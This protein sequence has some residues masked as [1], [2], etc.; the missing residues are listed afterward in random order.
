MT[1]AKMMMKTFF[2]AII[3]FGFLGCSSK[4]ELFK[5]KE[6]E[7]AQANEPV[8]ET[9]RMEETTDRTVCQGPPSPKAKLDKG[10]WHLEFMGSD[11]IKRRYIYEFDEDSIFIQAYCSGDG[12]EIR[13]RLGAAAVI[14]ENTIQISESDS[15]T[16]SV[17]GL[18]GVAV[19]CT[20]EIEPTGIINYSFVGP[21]LQFEENGKVTVFAPSYL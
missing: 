4:G 11:G 7:E 20:A 10:I 21:C 13:S 15:D 17:P 12:I 8:E 9:V 3:A 14:T 6:E 18:T 2:I 5:E 1:M 16:N 19:T